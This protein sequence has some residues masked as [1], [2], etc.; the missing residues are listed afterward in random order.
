M[1]DDMIDKSARLKE[2]IGGYYHVTIV[3][4]DYPRWLVILDNGA[5]LSV[6]EDELEFD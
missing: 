1:I 4:V 6:Y 2:P 3:G 5:M